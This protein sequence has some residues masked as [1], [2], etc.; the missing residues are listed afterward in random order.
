MPPHVLPTHLFGGP[1]RPGGLA[2]CS[3]PLRKL[4]SP[5]GQGGTWGDWSPR[6][7]RLAPK[8]RAFRRRPSA[9]G[10]SGLAR[11]WFHGRFQASALP[12]VKLWAVLRGARHPEGPGSLARHWFRG[13]F[14]AAFWAPGRAGGLSPQGPPSRRG[15]ACRRQAGG[16]HFQ[17]VGLAARRVVLEACKVLPTGTPT[18]GRG[19]CRHTYFL[20]TC[21]AA[22]AGGT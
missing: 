17:P 11:H 20:P 16:F 6:E 21:L 13:R 2:I 10:G 8:G 22:F 3:T 14:Q 7:G 12:L 4:I 5:G 1:G 9:P 15:A 18:A 19:K